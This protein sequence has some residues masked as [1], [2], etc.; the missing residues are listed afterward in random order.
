MNKIFIIIQREYLSRIKKKSFLI[1]T[2]LAPVGFL[3]LFFS[4]FIIQRMGSETK[5]IAI[6]DESGIFANESFPDA[7]DGSYYFHIEKNKNELTA[8]LNE[9]SKYDAMIVIPADYSIETPQN[10][11]ISFLSVKKT[12]I[13]LQD[14]INELFSEKIQKIYAQKLGLTPDKTEKLAK[15]ISLNFQKLDTEDKNN[16]LYAAIGIGYVV[17]FLIYMVLMIYGTMILKGVM[18]EKSSRVMEVLASSVKPIELMMGKIIGI[19]AVGLT[20]FLIWILLM[21]AA[22]FLLLPMVG[23][24]GSSMPSSPQMSGAASQIDPDDI[25]SILR[26]LSAINFTKVVGFF[27]VFFLGGYLIYGSLFAALGAAV[28]EDADNQSMIMPVMT[29]IIISM[30]LLF[31]VLQDPEGKLAFWASIFPLSSPIIM[32]ALIPFNPPWWQILL[33]VILLVVG[34]LAAVSIAAKIYRVGMLLYGKKPSYKE[35]FKW[36]TIKV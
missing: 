23:M 5:H 10:P 25:Q 4:S 32:P 35:I 11:S 2:I 20:Q 3:L 22:N 26:E 15:N 19:G 30:L 18:E 24:S 8:R 27:F 36:L 29:P 16:T 7:A 28:G 34:F 21:V 9:K 31:Q 14:K 33:S 13:T 12:G 1:S 17:G 6:I